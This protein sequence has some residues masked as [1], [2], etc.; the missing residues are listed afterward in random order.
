MKNLHTYLLL[1]LFG[2]LSQAGF[3]QQEEYPH[4]MDTVVITDAPVVDE[5]VAVPAT[6]GEDLSRYVVP[7]EAYKSFE[8]KWDWR[9]FPADSVSRFE[10]DPEF[11][12]ANYPFQEDEPIREKKNRSVLNQSWIFNLLWILILL[13]FVGLLIWFLS[14]NGIGFFKNDQALVKGEAEGMQE[15]EDIFSIPY[16]YKIESAEKD[17]NYRLAVRYLF[18]Q[19]LKGLSE[20]GTIL[21]KPDRT[22]LDYLMQLHGR[23]EYARFFQAMRHY[24]YVWYGQFSPLEGNYREIR[25]FF[26]DFYKKEGMA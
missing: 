25:Q 2:F 14:Q 24:E 9:K 7:K 10:K 26:Q 19:L 5:V 13:S 3:A 23:P 18:L 8:D 1:A 12:Y 16:S 15:E 21:Y 11:W 20:R 4:E 6:T 22:N 17:G